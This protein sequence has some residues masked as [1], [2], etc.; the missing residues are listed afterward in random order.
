LEPAVNRTDKHDVMREFL[1]PNN[2]SAFIVEARCK[3]AAGEQQWSRLF[4]KG[5][6]VRTGLDNRAQR[7][8]SKEARSGDAW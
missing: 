7:R 8:R 6:K 5:T 3:P 1:D 2:L 4:G